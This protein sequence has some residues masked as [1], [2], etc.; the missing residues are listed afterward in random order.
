MPLRKLQQWR[1]Q[2]PAKS[3]AQKDKQ[4]LCDNLPIDK[5]DSLAA[6]LICEILALV[7][8]PL[9]LK[10]PCSSTNFK[11]V[12]M[13]RP[14][15]LVHVPVGKLCHDTLGLNQPSPVDLSDPYGTMSVHVGEL[16]LDMAAVT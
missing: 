1:R 2:I 16:M 4:T 6:P 11:T 7:Y 10:H 3:G 13:I 12:Y 9:E 8:M 14:S 15:N 5:G